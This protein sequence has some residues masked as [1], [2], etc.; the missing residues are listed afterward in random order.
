MQ[1]AEDAREEFT[2]LDC[3]TQSRALAALQITQAEWRAGG[4]ALGAAEDC[5]TRSF[6]SKD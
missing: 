4:G 6:V 1:T 3:V 5:E 2:W